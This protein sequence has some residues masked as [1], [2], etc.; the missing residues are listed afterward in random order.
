MDEYL[1]KV[2]PFH[3]AP[4]ELQAL[5]D[6]GGDED[7]LALVP[8]SLKGQWIGWLE[9]GRFGVCDVNEYLQPDGSV[10]CIGVHA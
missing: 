10:V 9:V 7:W 8:P 6:N 4:P 5:S 1:I 3:H 2:W